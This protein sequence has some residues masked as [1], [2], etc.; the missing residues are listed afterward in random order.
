MTNAMRTRRVVQQGALGAASVRT[1][2]GIGPDSCT[3]PSRRGLAMMLVLITLSV[4]TVVTAATLSARSMS[5]YVAENALDSAD[6][7]WAAESG[8]NFAV[9]MLQTR[10]DWEA[11]AGTLTTDLP[12]AGGT[13]TV[14]ITNMAG[15]PPT[16]NDRDLIVTSISVVNGIESTTQKLVRISP[17]ADVETALDPFV[18]EF[19]VYARHAVNIN[20][21]ADLRP[22]GA[23][24]E[25]ATG[26]VQVATS[27]ASASD[28]SINVAAMPGGTVVFDKWAS[29]S[30]PGMLD[31]GLAHQV[32]PLG[33]PD[34]TLPAPSW[35]GSLSNTSM[36]D[37][38]IA[39][40]GAT[41]LP[42]DT[43]YGGVRIFDDAV[44]TLTDTANGG[45]SLGLL[46]IDKWGTLII[47][48]NVE[49]WLRSGGGMVVD[50]LGCIEFTP[51]S[52]LTVWLRDNN[53]VI[54][55]KGGWLAG[56]SSGNPDNDPS[57]YRDPR[58]FVLW[59][60]VAASVSL[61]NGAKLNAEIRV[62]EGTVTLGNGSRLYGRVHA[63]T[64][65]MTTS[66]RLFY[67]PTL[68]N[69]MG[70]TD[71]NGPLYDSNGAPLAGLENA[72][73]TYTGTAADFPATMA[74]AVADAGGLPIIVPPVGVGSATARDGSQAQA[75]PVPTGALM[76]EQESI[77][78]GSISYEDDGTTTTV[79]LESLA[80]LEDQQGE[81][82]QGGGKTG[83]TTNTQT[84]Q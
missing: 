32:L 74:Q 17:T 44:V 14:T 24:P 49:L 18:G 79:T 68:D 19:A 41:T 39:G 66:S 70:F 1:R 57:M 21:G 60:H 52:T 12:I 4:T 28:V 82:L 55:G 9:A 42:D 15:Q 83:E 47:D 81:N 77:Y 26:K 50:H 11:L 38:L 36:A 51:G 67:D 54:N 22:W 78:N 69:R 31:A 73:D 30:A 61:G 63:G 2:A 35:V 84:V 76:F 37:Q 80:L 43:K 53:I 23:S 45:Y 20:G 34:T 33:L 62:P 59:S 16:S 3:A 75:T 64:F 25:G 56:A 6:A 72:I 48:G 58:D 65:N 46:T 71:L 10:L 40:A 27:A 8:A 29:S 13:S 5:P 7:R